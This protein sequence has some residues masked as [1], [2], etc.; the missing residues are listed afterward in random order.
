MLHDL[1]QTLFGTWPTIKYYLTGIA[2]FTS[3][4]FVFPAER[5]QSWSDKRVSF[6]LSV[7]YCALIPFAIYLPTHY[8]SEPIL[9]TIGHPLFSANLDAMFGAGVVGWSVRNFLLPFVPILVV[10]FFYYWTHRFQH[11]FPVLWTQHKLH[12]T[13][14]ALCSMSA[15]RHHWLEEPIKIFTVWIPIGILL[16]VTA[17]GGSI[18]LPVLAYWGFFIHANVRLPMGPLT[19]VFSGPQIHRL[20]HSA[21][22]EHFDKNFAANFPIWDVLF[23][24]YCHPKKGEW[25]ATGMAD[26]ERIRGVM[27]GLVLPFDGV[28]NWL[29][30]IPQNTGS[31][32][33]K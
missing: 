30:R 20:H 24:T 32:N 23:G 1:L 31:L 25:P 11:T 5:G 12:H 4:E 7:I 33:S 22:P 10:D 15:L 2:I 3:L 9:R 16:S 26:G 21:L 18:L 14:Y 17:G 28:F 29:R 19:R 6:T 8:I 13:E 27:H